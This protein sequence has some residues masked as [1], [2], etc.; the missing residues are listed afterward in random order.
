MFVHP[1]ATTGN[2][3]YRSTRIGSYV[4]RDGMVAITCNLL[5]GDG[6]Y[7]AETSLHIQPDDIDENGDFLVAQQYLKQFIIR[8]KLKMIHTGIAE[9]GLEQVVYLT[10]QVL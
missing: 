7:V 8:M 6:I 4:D 9:T 2:A 5:G 3:W 1:T 10:A